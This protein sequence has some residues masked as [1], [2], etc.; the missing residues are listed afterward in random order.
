MGRTEE[1][2]WKGAIWKAAYGNLSIRD[3]LTTLKGFGPMEILQFE[4]PGSF[5]GEMSLCLSQDGTKEISIYYL[6]VEGAKRQGGGREALQWL[7]KIFKGELF[8]EDSG[9]IR[10]ER[11]T[12]ESIAFWIK[13]LREGVIDALYADQCFLERGM[14]D[15]EIDRI[16]ERIGK[17]SN[18]APERPGAADESS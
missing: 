13:M 1:V 4:K 18:D 3:I 17:S 10:V 8:V 15:A 14:N 12:K 6:E 16:E 9:F 7:K 11:P 2:H 5:K